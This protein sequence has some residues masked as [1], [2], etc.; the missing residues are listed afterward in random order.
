[1]KLSILIA[2]A[3]LAAGAAQAQPNQKPARTTTICLD[4]SGA[5]LPAVC[6]VPGICTCPQGEQVTVAVCPP[7]VRQPAETVA[8]DRARRQA[9]HNGSL[10]GATWQ[11]KPM[12]VTRRHRF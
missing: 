7:G 6:Q 11:G 4:V 2:A 10:V 8:Y 3:A 1:M 12:C 9:L 5:P